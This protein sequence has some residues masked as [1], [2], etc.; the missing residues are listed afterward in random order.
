[1]EKNSR[2]VTAAQIHTTK[3]IWR[4]SCLNFQVN[5]REEKHPKLRKKEKPKIIK[6]KSLCS[7]HRSPMVSVPTVILES[8]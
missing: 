4:R 8:H 6:E 3:E 5:L 7:S 2:K 1:V